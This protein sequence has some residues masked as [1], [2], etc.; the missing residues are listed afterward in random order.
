MKD[1]CLDYKKRI[2]ETIEHEKK[3]LKKEKVILSK[4]WFRF[5]RVGD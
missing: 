2:L 4:S 1:L 5:K 3:I